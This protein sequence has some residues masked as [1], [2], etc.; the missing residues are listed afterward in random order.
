MTIQWV[1]W[2]LA[3]QEAL[4]SDSYHHIKAGQGGKTPKV[5]SW[6]PYAHAWTCHTPTQAYS[7]PQTCPSKPQFFT[8]KID[9]I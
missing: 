4:S 7:S 9:E 3:E 2:L 1:K 6:P 5:D 8:S